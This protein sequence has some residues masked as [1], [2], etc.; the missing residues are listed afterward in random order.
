MP[1]Y[2]LEQ[3]AIADGHTTIAGVDEVGRGP[4]AGPVVAGAAILDIGLLPDELLKAL[5]DSKKLK[6]TRRFEIYEWMKAEAGILL[7]I[8]MASVEEVDEINILQASLRAM[9]RAV[10]NLPNAPSYVLVDGNKPPKLDCPVQC[11]VKGDAKSL[12]IA[13]A[14]IAAK[15]TRD[16]IM[17]DLDQAFPGYGWNTNSGYGTKAHQDGLK[18]LG[19]TKHHRRSFKPVK[20]A[21]EASPD[22][23][24]P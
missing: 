4:W 20:A 11:V 24:S 6:P 17:E 3:A 7:G 19:V 1:D 8:G 15:V 14:S 12:S 22:I 10:E 16:A 18:R 5:D 13:A 21:L 2:V 23:E 9:R